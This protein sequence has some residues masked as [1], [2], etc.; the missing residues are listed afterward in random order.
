MVLSVVTL[1]ISFLFPDVKKD[2][3]EDKDSA[4]QEKK[5]DSTGIFS[6]YPFLL[7]NVF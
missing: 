3:P 6:K 2:L 7:S 4:K 5:T 1:G